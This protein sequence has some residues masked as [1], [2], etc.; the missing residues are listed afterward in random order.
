MEGGVDAARGGRRRPVEL[1]DFC[2]PALAEHPGEPDFVVGEEVADVGLEFIGEGRQ[3]GGEHAAQAEAVVG[4]EGGMEELDVS[5][6]GSSRGELLLV[7]LDERRVE[8]LAVAAHE[9][10]DEV[11]LG[12][13]VVVDG[14]GFDADPLGEITEAEAVVSAV[15]DELLGDVEDFG[16]AGGVDEHFHADANLLPDKRFARE[17]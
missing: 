1:H 8:P 7:D 9:G 2:G 15:L 12:A 11:L 4:F 5:L 16:L 17:K 3:F 10:S 14:R 6:E 13:E